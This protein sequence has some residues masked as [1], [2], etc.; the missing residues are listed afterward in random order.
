[1]D[2]K[3]FIRNQIRRGVFLVVTANI[4]ERSAVRQYYI[5]QPGVVKDES[6]P[7]NE[8][9]FAQY[10]KYPIV[11]LH[12]KN[13]GSYVQDSAIDSTI[14]ARQKYHPKASFMVG[15]AFG[16]NADTQNIG[17]VLVTEKI[18]PYERGKIT[19]TGDVE[20]FENRNIP[21]SI[22]QRLL[23][24][25][26]NEWYNNY[27]QRVI[28]GY[29]LS[30]EKIVDSPEFKHKIIYDYFK[31]EIAEK[32]VGG[33]MEAIGFSI[34]HP[35]TDHIV[36][37]SICDWGEKK[38]TISKEKDQI[39][40][41]NSSA[42][43]LYTIFCSNN[44]GYVYGI[45][46]QTIRPVY[47]CQINGYRMYYY[48]QLRNYTYDTLAS[49]TGITTDWLRK[50]ESVKRVDGSACFFRT[51]RKMI[52]TI[53]SKLNCERK[54]MILDSTDEEIFLY[55]S[56][57]TNENTMVPMTDIQ[58]VVFDFEGT[59]TMNEEKISSWERLWKV[60]GDPDNLCKELHSAY[61]NKQITHSE[62]C[63]QTEKHFKK[64]NMHEE[65][66]LE[67][68]DKIKLI[69]N[70][71][72]VFR[73]LVANNI[74][75]YICSGSINTIITSVM[76]NCLD[77]ITEY[78][79]NTFIYQNRR[80]IEIKGTKFDFEGKRDYVYQIASENDISPDKI[81]FVGNSDNDI[82][83]HDSG[84]RTIVVNPHMISPYLKKQWDYY[85]EPFDDF[86]KILP[87]LLP[88]KHTLL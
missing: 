36:I 62:W 70:V 35:N 30:G 14:Y 17:D 25:C 15:I 2:S 41:A 11:H 16:R 65:L 77:Y 38:N 71:E 48:R 49:K 8:C 51:S 5:D 64:H 13:Q 47:N 53:E 23:N 6:E 74:K 10:G 88:T 83:V 63:K 84:A 12:L 3:Q 76:R 42:D 46:S 75:I 18:L 56:R 87:Y 1:M 37:K 69:T 78:R 79:S 80:L 26:P 45:P 29:L 39:F 59:L 54:L 60:V 27:Q 28:K 7:T 40:A 31:P 32:I 66:V 24:L 68:A 21:V 52:E 58:H 44:L 33:D 55:K 85:I 57:S 82:W 4:H 20:F 9:F 19:K 43:Y 22:S 73:I 50:M 86:R 72:E 61:Q 81:A 34:A 67:A